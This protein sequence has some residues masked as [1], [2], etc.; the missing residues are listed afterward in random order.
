MVDV[1]VAPSASDFN[2]AMAA[3]L[4]ERWG[5]VLDD[6]RTRSEFQDGTDTERAFIAS[7]VSKKMRRTE[8]AGAADGA[9]D[10]WHLLAG[11]PNY[12]SLLSA[13]G[14]LDVTHKD[15]TAICTLLAGHPSPV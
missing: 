14:P 6:C 11:V 13:L 10:Q 8:G 5:H 15:Y 2:E 1:V 12:K 3:A 4:D 9:D 7:T